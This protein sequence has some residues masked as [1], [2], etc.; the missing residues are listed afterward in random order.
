MRFTARLLLFALFCAA[1]GLAAHADTVTHFVITGADGIF[2]FSLVSSAQPTS[3]DTTYDQFAV[4]TASYNGQ[5]L[6]NNSVDFYS[7]AA[8]GGLYLFNN[9]ADF[10]LN[11]YGPSVFSGTPANPVFHNG[12]FT[13]TSGSSSVNGVSTSADGDLLTISTASSV[14]EPSTLA[15]F[16]TGAIGLAG[17]TRRL[18]HS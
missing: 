10:Y 11:E 8:G 2:S 3:S 12:T 15:L 18:L 17:L 6:A 7:P 5:A 4:S 14:P 9:A 13:F 1:S 16:G